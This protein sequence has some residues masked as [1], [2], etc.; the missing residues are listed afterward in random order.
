MKRLFLVFFF[1]G[2]IIFSGLPAFAE[3]A[4]GIEELPYY[5]ET[6]GVR[7]GGLD[8]LKT[9]WGTFLLSNP[10]I[11]QLDS[12]LTK[13]NIVF[14]ILFAHNYE[15]SFVFALIL[16]FWF[17][18][19]GFSFNVIRAYST[20]SSWASWFMGLLLAVVFAHVGFFNLLT[21]PFMWLLFSEK[22]WWVSLILGLVLVVG[23]ILLFRFIKQWARTMRKKRLA[24]REEAALQ[25]TE[26][27][28]K[29]GEGL[30]KGL[31]RRDFISGRW[32][33]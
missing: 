5:N 30:E 12:V 11:A 33:K 18:F 15:V 6:S 26:I 24:A 10:L 20:F 27:G 9:Q 4:P 19:W 8:Y 17:C 13:G 23:L 7:E 16:I 28:A 14:F 1:L 3:E 29:F 32:G 21:K 31:S 25:K 2:L 22:P